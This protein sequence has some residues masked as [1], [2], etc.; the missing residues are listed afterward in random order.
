MGIGR[1]SSESS[2]GGDSQGYGGRDLSIGGVSATAFSGPPHLEGSLSISSVY[3]FPTV[4]TLS[5]FSLFIFSTYCSEFISHPILFRLRVDDLAKTQ[6]E[7]FNTFSWLFSVAGPPELIVLEADLVLDLT[8]IQTFLSRTS[9]SQVALKSSHLLPT[10]SILNSTVSSAVAS[11][12]EITSSAPVRIHQWQASHSH[13]SARNRAH[14]PKRTG[15]VT[16]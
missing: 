16:S 13:S 1:W 2:R 11:S 3:G 10:N 9:S 7:F 5:I 12:S 14:A 6:T 15:F 4:R 8:A